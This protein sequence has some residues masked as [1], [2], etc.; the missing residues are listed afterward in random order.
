MLF[1]VMI[2]FNKQKF[3]HKLVS[4]LVIRVISKTTGLQ[5]SYITFLLCLYELVLKCDEQF[6]ECDNHGSLLR[7]YDKAKK[8]IF[9]LNA[10]ISV[11]LSL[12]L[13]MQKES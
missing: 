2:S 10:T 6:A 12:F 1:S 4:K 11:P 3:S 5:K 13:Q 8:W 9:P 7:N